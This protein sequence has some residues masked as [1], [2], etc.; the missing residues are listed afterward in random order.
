M[1]AALLITSALF[2][3]AIA[4]DNGMDMSM[5]EGMQLTMGSMLSYLHFTPGDNLWF[6]GWVPKS[7]GAMVGTCIGL[8][9]LGLVDRWVAACR[10][11]MEAHW[12]KKAQVIIANKLNAARRRSS[13]DQASIT[14]MQSSPA[15]AVL[16]MRNAPPFIPAHD[17]TRGIM[18]MGQMALNFILMLAVMTFQVAFI[19]SI[20][21]GLGVGEM[22][23]GRYIRGVA[24]AH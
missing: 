24:H 18:H 4:H 7:A 9:L 23:F 16:T 11:V 19:L 13:E 15:A 10:A 6:L 1:F 12:A 17:I 21:V 2:R 3:L 5:D 22:F 14:K 8:F 20:I